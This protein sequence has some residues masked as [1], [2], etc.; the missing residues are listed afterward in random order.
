[1]K[2]QDTLIVILFTL[3][4][5]AVILLVLKGVF[6]WTNPT[7]A[8]PGGSGSYPPQYVTSLPGSPSDGQEVVYEADVANRVYWHLK[9]KSSSGKWMK[10]GGPPLR[11]ETGWGGN[12]QTTSAPW[13]DLPTVGPQITAPLGGTYHVRYG[14]LNLYVESPDYVISQYGIK[15]GATEPSLYSTAVQM[16]VP[17]N[18]GQWPVHASFKKDNIAAGT[19]FKARY[20]IGGGAGPAY[21]YGRWLEI[22]PVYIQ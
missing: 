4:I 14:L 22:D 15:V 20:G 12:E 3:L 7:Q 1:M 5:I 18:Y 19:V 6:A 21:Y 10:I 2:K 9:Y 11:A 13:T 16:R 8:P 17:D